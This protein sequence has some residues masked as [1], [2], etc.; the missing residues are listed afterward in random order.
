MALVWTADAPASDHGVSAANRILAQKVSGGFPL[1][2]K[3]LT[4]KGLLPGKKQA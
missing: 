2:K 3:L 4:T 1:L